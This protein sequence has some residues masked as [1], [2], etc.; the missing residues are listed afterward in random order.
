MVYVAAGRFIATITLPS[1]AKPKFWLSSL[2][3]LRASMQAPATSTTERHACT[4]TRALLAHDEWALIARPE[5]RSAS[6]GFVRV[7]SHA[8][9]APKMTPVASA[10]ARAHPSTAGDGVTLTGRK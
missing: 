3:R 2:P 5:A 8:G 9:A 7:A 6:A 1:T 10:S 4:A